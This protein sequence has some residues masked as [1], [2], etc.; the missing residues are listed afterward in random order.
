MNMGSAMGLANVGELLF[1]EALPSCAHW[2]DRV[3]QQYAARGFDNV[4]MAAL[5]GLAVETRPSVPG[6]MQVTQL[7]RVGPHGSPEALQRT[8]LPIC[9]YSQIVEEARAQATSAAAPTLEMGVAA[10]N[11][12]IGEEGVD[13]IAEAENGRRVWPPTALQSSACCKDAVDI[14]Q[15]ID[16]NIQDMGVDDKLLACVPGMYTSIVE[17]VLTDRLLTPANRD[18][19]AALGIGAPGGRRDDIV[20]AQTRAHALAALA[21]ATGNGDLGVALTQL[22]SGT[23]SRFARKPWE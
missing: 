23:I 10:G 16:K 13:R 18:A 6:P 1:Q 15:S 4:D 3:I 12:L 17:A 5:G 11:R 2:G 21:F 8:E 19:Y 20:H 7:H 9:S 14:T 22:A